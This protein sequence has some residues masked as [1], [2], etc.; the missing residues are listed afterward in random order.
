MVHQMIPVAL[1]DQLDQSRAKWLLQQVLS[2]PLVQTQY[3]LFLFTK[4]RIKIHMLI[5]RSDLA[6]LSVKVDL[7]LSPSAKTLKAKG[8]LWQPSY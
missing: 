3:T 4:K 7:K 1:L 6:T 5:T 8:T 2:E